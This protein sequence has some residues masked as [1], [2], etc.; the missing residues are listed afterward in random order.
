MVVILYDVYVFI[1]LLV[2]LDF[3]FYPF[4]T[5]SARKMASFGFWYLRL[6][7][8]T[9]VHESRRSQVPSLGSR[10]VKTTNFLALKGLSDK[11]II[12]I[13]GKMFYTKEGTGEFNFLCHVRCIRYGNINSVPTPSLLK[14]SY[15]VVSTL[16]QKLKQCYAQK[17]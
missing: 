16:V 17:K 11:Q 8:Y 15:D 7:S 3:F 12:T 4:N 5:L 13:K 6:P 1:L 2:I 9:M 14:R 10:T